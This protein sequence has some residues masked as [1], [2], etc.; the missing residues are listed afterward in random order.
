MQNFE[1]SGKSETGARIAYVFAQTNKKISNCV[2]YCGPSNKSVDV[3]FG[4]I[5]CNSY[6]TCMA[7]TMFVVEKFVNLLDAT[8]E[9]K[10]NI[11]RIYSSGIERLDYPGAEHHNVTWKSSAKCPDWAKP[12]ALHHLLRQ[13]ENSKLVI[14]ERRL[15][16]MK[17]EG[18][19]PT[20]KLCYEYRCVLRAAE[21]EFFKNKKFDIVFCTCNEASGGRIKR[22]KSLAPRQCIIDECGMAYEPET[23]VPISLCEH[24]V[25][26]GDHQQLQPVIDYKPARD[27]GLTTSLFERYANHHN[28]FLYTLGIQYR[29]VSWLCY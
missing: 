11:L 7:V 3:V 24:V 22:H 13:D 4:K 18:E 9:L 25:L 12:Y 21:E 27:C 1:G 17:E 5:I 14:F 6:C 19:I 16:R 23:I 2:L 26:I 29:M 15:K 20:A 8:E 10:L 28:E